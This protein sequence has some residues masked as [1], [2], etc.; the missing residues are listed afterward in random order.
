MRAVDPDTGE[1]FRVDE[2]ELL[3]WVHV[4]EVES[5]LTTALRAGLRL[6]RAEVDRYY[7]EQRRSAE[8]IGL[9]PATVPG[10]ATEIDEY[11]QAI[12]PQLHLTRDGA[13]GALFL[14]APPM[15]WH[16]GLTPVRLA[17]F[18]VSGVG[19]GLLPAWARRMYGLPGL[20]TTDLSASLS[21]RALR[22]SLALLPLRAVQDPVY[23]DALRRAQA[24]KLAG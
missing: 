12:R 5:F 4:T 15:P 6:D 7:D 11:Y 3:R 10:S 8:L 19:F 23:R 17:W 24:L 20:P 9:D 16:L 2:P 22:R 13:S 21:V 18:G 14:A 1:T